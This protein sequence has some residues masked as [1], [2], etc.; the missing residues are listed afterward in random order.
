MDRFFSDPKAVARLRGGL[1]GIYLDAYACSLAEQGYA[2]RTAR[3]YLEMIATLG[4]WLERRQLAASSLDEKCLDAFLKHQRRRGKFKPRHE[5]VLHA[6]LKTLRETGVL[7]MPVPKVVERPLERWVRIHATYLTE[8]RG[9][10][11]ATIT[12]YSPIVRQ[13][14]VE[15][16]GV[17][18]INPGL[19]VASDITGF[20][21]RHAHDRA[22][23]SKQAQLLGTALRSFLRFLR[24]RGQ[25]ARDLASCVPSVA[26]WRLDSLPKALEASQ[27]KDVLRHCSGRTAMSRRDRAI[28]L[29][30]ARLGL[31]GGEVVALTLDDIDWETGEIT[32]LGKGQ[33]RNRLPLPRDVGRALAAYLKDR[34]AESPCRRVFLRSKAPV[35]GFASSVAISEIVRRALHRAGLHPPRTGAH[36]FRHAL[37]IRL[38]GKGRTLNEVR[39]VLGH[40]HLDTTAIYAKVDLPSLQALAQPWPGGAA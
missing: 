34:R 39:E 21:Q 12:I 3:G 14:L 20:I 27:V 5:G 1:L 28:L 15:R 18:P 6:F 25:I 4:K 36:L 8:E 35:R 23:N 40:R 31:R 13:F 29:L 17:K 24:L 9:L 16:F 19:L 11:Q 30:L 2:R 32:V 33:R 10:T 38:L 26:A 7:K 37:A 22:R